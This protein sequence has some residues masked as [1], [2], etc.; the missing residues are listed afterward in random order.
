MTINSHTKEKVCYFSMWLIHKIVGVKKDKFYF[1]GMVGKYNDNS[2]AVSE[3]LKEIFPTAKIYWS[4]TEKGSKDPHIPNYV[5]PIVGVVKQYLH[6]ATSYCWISCG[7]IERGIYKGKNQLYVDL[8]HGDRG[9]KKI[10]NDKCSE[11][12]KKNRTFNTD[13]CDLMT[14]GS[15]FFDKVINSAFCYY[16][17]I[18]HTGCPR[19][20]L[21]FRKDELLKERILNELGIDSKYKILLYAPTFRDHAMYNQQ[22]NIDI[23]KTLQAF[24]KATFE[25]WI[26]LGRFHPMT[27]NR[28]AFISKNIIDVT[29]YYDMVDLLYI[30]DAHI[31]DYS[32]TAGDFVLLHRP[33]FLFHAD[34]ADYQKNDREFYFSMD[35]TPFWVAS[36]QEEL[37]NLIITK[38]QKVS[39]EENCKAILDFYGATETGHA[40]DDVINF[41]MQ[42]G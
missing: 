22:E 25:K 2:R 31:T 8:W 5:H 4:F 6:M 7:V 15:S 1:I 37:E 17:T 39:I 11:D 18:L 19:N 40:S 35:D 16:G 10:L 24:E 23:D 29:N 27:R 26:C 42:K 30:S 13:F 41:I 32:S 20:D 38:M 3:R 12:S 21:L 9:F 33:V 34:K 36:T 28:N 14:S